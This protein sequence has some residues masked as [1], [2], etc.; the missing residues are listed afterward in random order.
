MPHEAEALT[1]ATSLFPDRPHENAF[2]I[3]GPRR[4][5][6]HLLTFRPTAEQLTTWLCH[7]EELDRRV[8]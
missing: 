4:I 7:P 6:A 3:E 5:F 8:C 2:F 1:V